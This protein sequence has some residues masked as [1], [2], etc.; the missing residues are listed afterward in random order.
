[1]GRFAHLLSALSFGAPPHAGIALGFDRLVAMLCNAKSIR[2]VIAFPKS[3]SGSDPVFK[4]P[5]PSSADVLREYGLKP[6]S[7]AG[8]GAGPAA[9]GVAPSAEP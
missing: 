3:T 9:V 2:E 7:E 4:S 5:S 1:M 6:V 8:A